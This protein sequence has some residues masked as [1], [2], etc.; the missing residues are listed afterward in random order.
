MN[1]SIE[2]GSFFKVQKD[3]LCPSNGSTLVL[4]NYRIKL[5]LTI[6][7]VSASF[8]SS[9]AKLGHQVRN[10]LSEIESSHINIILKLKSFLLKTFEFFHVAREVMPRGYNLQL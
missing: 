7:V 8:I 5:R 4:A 6:S 10:K 9:R 2:N 1:S 3:I